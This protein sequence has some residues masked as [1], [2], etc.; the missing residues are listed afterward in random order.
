M[1]YETF[2]LI[3]CEFA[4]D[5]TLLS[6]NANASSVVDT[7]RQDL[8]VLQTYFCTNKLTLNQKNLS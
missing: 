6:F 7:I 8:D 1:I 4:D 3:I 2:W 5:I